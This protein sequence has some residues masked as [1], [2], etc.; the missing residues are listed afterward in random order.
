MD[1]TAETRY[2]S[3]SQPTLGEVMSCEET[4]EPT[5]EQVAN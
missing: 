1:W 3:R 4:R 5:V 2:L